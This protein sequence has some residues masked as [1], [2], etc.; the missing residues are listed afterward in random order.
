LG[1]RP[2]IIA[3]GVDFDLFVFFGFFF[4]NVLF[5]TASSAAPQIPLTVSEDAGIDPGL[6]R[7][8][9]WQSDA[10]TTRL[11]LIHSRLKKRSCILN[12]NS[13]FLWFS[14]TGHLFGNF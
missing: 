1:S 4:I 5:N 12:K 7:L 8:W 13:T 14:Y 9:H 3:K 10:L 2:A 11:D 6:L